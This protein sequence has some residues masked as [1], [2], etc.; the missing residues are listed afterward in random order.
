MEAALT[1]R[2]ALGEEESWWLGDKGTDS[3]PLTAEIFNSALNDQEQYIP[4][5]S[6][7]PSEASERLEPFPIT[8]RDFT[9]AR[10]LVVLAKQLLLLIFCH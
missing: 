4:N 10:M 1:L 5:I 6:V 3:V 7:S 9:Q 2:Y 8:L